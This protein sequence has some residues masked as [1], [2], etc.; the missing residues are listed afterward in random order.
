MKNYTLSFGKF[1]L[2]EPAP[3][4]FIQ[5]AEIHAFGVITVI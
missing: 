4:V 5:A 2:N 3:S 1:F